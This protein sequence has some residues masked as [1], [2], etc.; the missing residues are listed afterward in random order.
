M[1]PLAPEEPPPV[2]MGARDVRSV[3]R[4]AGVISA[5][6]FLSRVLGLVRE[7]VFAAQFGAGFAVDAFQVA[8]RIP[9]LL[10]DLFAE[11][12]MSAAFVPTLSRAQ[13]RSGPEAALRL[14]NL[15]INFL[16]VIV[17]A[18]CLVGILA[19]PWIVRVLAPGFAA[20]PGKLELTTLMTR[21]M[22]PFLVLVSI[23]AAVMGFLNTRRV[24]F[25]PAVAPAM[26]NLALIA[27]GFLIAPLCPRFGLE[28]IVGMAFGTLLGGLGQL[29]IQ[30]PALRAQGYR[31]RPQVSFRDPDVLR[32]VSLMT[33]AAVGIA[34]VQV[35]N[36]VSTFL[37]STL[38]EG[39]VSWL[40]YAYRLMQLPIGLF[41]VAIATVTLAEVAR[42]AAQKNIAGLK[43]TLSFS[44]RLVFLLTL[45]ATL[46]LIA[47][48]RPIVAL[49][50]QHGKFGASDTVE[51]AKALW[52]Y[53]AGL[54]AF[55][56][57]RVM[58]PAFYSL[59]MARIPVTVSFISIGITVGLNFL[60]M[61]P[62][63]H[64][65]LALATSIG[66]VLNFALLFWMLRSRI[67][68]I[69]GRALAFSA[70]RISLA[71]ALAGGAAWFTAGA[72]EGVTGLESL[73]ARLAVV[74]AG[75]AAAAVVFVGAATILRV[76]ELQ[77]LLGRLR[78]A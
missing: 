53:A 73:G 24:F 58:V 36:F 47:L 74:G 57:V 55:S 4:S 62:M 35:N 70:A 63:R 1:P 50:Y 19:A 14:T 56:A 76:E 51:T 39:S 71:A 11:G 77:R 37:A 8:F 30:V 60:L 67:G 46:V 17:S 78:G 44:L 49:L 48:A 42:H 21:I 69:G 61:G 52:A 32:M 54:A 7:Q 5:A 45:P 65:G 40:N 6:T 16:L 28:P 13:E 33:P 41:G 38:V 9:N 15:V 3:A 68:G 66:S 18:I 34:A 59:G 2:P 23:A 75:L 72:V 12:A 43:E 29:L 20:V 25:I 22:T 64:A 31:W 27:A 10:R 26:L